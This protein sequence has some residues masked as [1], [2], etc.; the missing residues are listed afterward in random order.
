MKKC[1]IMMAAA[2]LAAVACNEQE[3]KSPAGQWKIVAADGEMVQ[4]EEN[5]PYI[6]FGEGGKMHGCLG[7]NLANGE[8]K[9]RGDRLKI[10]NM[11]MTMMAGAPQDMAV[12]DKVREALNEVERISYSADTLK[13]SDSKGNVRLAMVPATDAE[14]SQD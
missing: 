1:V 13:L 14:V 4:T 7:V 12:E 8:Y 6:V 2:A 5:T 10:G 11:G 3:V 9:L